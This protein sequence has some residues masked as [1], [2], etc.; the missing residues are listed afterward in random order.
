MTP[1]QQQ[2]MQI[3]AGA[4]QQFTAGDYAG[5]LPRSTAPSDDCPTIR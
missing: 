5:A 1:D 4:R 2:A 3:F